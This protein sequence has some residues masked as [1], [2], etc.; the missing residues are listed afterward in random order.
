MAT[1]TVSTYRLILPFQVM[2]QPMESLLVATLADDA[3]FETIEPQT[4]DDPI[5]GKGMRVLRYRRDGRVDIYWQPGVSV[6]R[7]LFEIGA[8]VGD[9]AETSMD[10]AR[11]EIGPRGAVC[12]VAFT[13]AQGRRVALRVHE[14]APGKRPFPL[15]APVGEDVQQPR[16]LFL[17]YMPNVDFARRG[18]TRI[19]GRIGER[20]L[21]PA[22][23]PLP[24][25]GRR[26][27]FTRYA[28]GPVTVGMLNPPM[29]RPIVLD[30]PPAGSAE[31][32]GMRVSADDA[33]R[34][35]R[36][37]AGPEGQPVVV[38]FAPGFP[39]LDGLDEGGAARGR[40]SISLAGVLITGGAYQA[41]R[42]GQRAAV[43]L[44]VTDHW[45]P[46]GLP[47]SMNILTHLVRMFRTWPASYRWRGAVELGAEP[48]MSGAWERKS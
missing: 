11:L 25:Q 40:W 29:Q 30:V 28:A 47:L 32:E 46:A 13:D 23:L 24:L 7:E 39:R 20:A 19:E 16:M 15:L 48:A 44:D 33:G 10:P 14:D 21:R 5:N 4:F 18:A 17:V 42:A 2:M 31:V 27:Y 22:A 1:Q 6:N 35:V 26:V 43:E 12:D 38:N 34:V 36:I 41:T 3:E 37:S 45:K 8:G 9:F